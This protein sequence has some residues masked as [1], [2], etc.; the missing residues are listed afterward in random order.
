MNI[1]QAVTHSRIQRG[2][3]GALLFGGATFYFVSLLMVI[4]RTAQ[5]M[6][7]SALLWRLGAMIQNFI[8]AIYQVTAPYIG[9]VW[10]NVPTIDQTDP[11]TY[12]NLLFLGLVGAMIVGKQLVLAGRRLRG[13]IQRQIDRVEDLQWRSSMMQSRVAADTTIS[14]NTIG[15]IN[16]F[17]QPMPPNPEGEWW[18]RPWGIIGLSII[19]GYVVAV[20]AKLT[21][22]L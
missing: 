3:G 19:S 4:Y 21:G 18:T 1:Q 7:D 12:G 6:S 14:A 10:H 11:F 17:Q 5:T 22:M 16:I 13:R 15:Q 2:V 20:L 9:F 8:A